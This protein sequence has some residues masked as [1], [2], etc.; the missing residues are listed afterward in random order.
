MTTTEQLHGIRAYK[1]ESES[2]KETETTK[3]TEKEEEVTEEERQRHQT[4]Y[5][6]L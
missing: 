5:T 3:G 1:K 2:Q 6:T 4:I